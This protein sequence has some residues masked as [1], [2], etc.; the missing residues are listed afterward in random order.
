MTKPLRKT[1]WDKDNV[2]FDSEGLAMQIMDDEGYALVTQYDGAPELAPGVPLERG[3]I[4]KEYPGTST[5]K[6]VQALIDQF[7]LPLAQIKEDFDLGDI[8]DDQVAIALAEDVTRKTIDG[9]RQGLEAIPGIADALRAIDNYMGGIE[10]RASCTTSP[11]DRMNISLE[12]AVDPATGENAG[13]ADLFPDVDDR[14]ISGYDYDNKYVYFFELHPDWD[15]AECA[16]FED[17]KSGVTKAKASHD[18]VRVIGTVAAQYYPD[19]AEQATVLMQAGADVVVSHADDMPKALEWLDNG[20][21]AET[22]PTFTAEVWTQDAL[23]APAQDHTQ[24]FQPQ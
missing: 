22:R 14:R 8:A 19:K 21:T 9:F 23:P 16:I 2:L 20:L 12:C 17:S 11:A 5:D 18:D 13:L 15:P 4:Y 3:Y 24:K 10:N 7:D 1:I 6:I